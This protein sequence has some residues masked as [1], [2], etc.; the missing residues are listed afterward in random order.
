MFKFTFDIVHPGVYPIEVM[1]GDDKLPTFHVLVLTEQ[2]YKSYKLFQVGGKAS[3]KGTLVN[4]VQTNSDTTVT[5]RL[6]TSVY[7]KVAS[8]DNT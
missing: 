2:E 3:F 5:I 6:S 7:M 8:N 4:D 1:L